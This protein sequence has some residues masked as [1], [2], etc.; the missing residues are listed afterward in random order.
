MVDELRPL[1]EASH[2]SAV[3]RALIERALRHLGG[4]YA[5]EMH[6]SVTVK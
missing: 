5:V 6:H 2:Y 3:D 1:F 4:L